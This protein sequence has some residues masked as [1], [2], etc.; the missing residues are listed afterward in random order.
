MNTKFASL[1]L[2]AA[3][4]ITALPVTST[5]TLA[6]VGAAGEPEVPARTDHPPRLIAPPAQLRQL[7]FRGH[8]AVGAELIEAAI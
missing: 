1:I 5:A 6:Q 2:A 8:V 4:A 3:V 7:P